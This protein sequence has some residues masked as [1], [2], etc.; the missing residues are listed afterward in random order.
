MIRWNRRSFLRLAASVGAAGCSL[1]SYASALTVTHEVVISDFEFSK[2]IATARPGDIIRWINK[3][4]VPHT[5]TAIDNSWDTGEIKVGA[6]GDVKVT[7]N[8][9]AEYFC[10][11]HPMMKA[12]VKLE[13]N[14]GSPK[15]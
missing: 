7:E 9:V 14:Q 4:I 12:K 11:Y 5:A 8:F 15:T 13:A 6:F 10:I 2:L 1:P 3:D